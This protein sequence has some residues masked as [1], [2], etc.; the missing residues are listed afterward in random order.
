MYTLYLD[1][2]EFLGFYPP[3]IKLYILWSMHITLQSSSNKQLSWLEIHRCLVQA[4]KIPKNVLFLH[5]SSL[6]PPFNAS[7]PKIHLYNNMCYTSYAVACDIAKYIITLFFVKNLK[8]TNFMLCRNVAGCQVYSVRCGVS[9]KC[10][11][12][13]A[14]KWYIIQDKLL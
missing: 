1:A 5:L 12:C 6:V 11:N 2:F 3:G 14:T 9:N 10:I 4:M 7:Q 13:L 8:T